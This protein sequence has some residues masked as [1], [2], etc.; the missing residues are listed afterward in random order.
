MKRLYVLWFSVLLLSFSSFAQEFRGT[1]IGR[2]TDSS[3]AVIANCEVTVRNENT[4]TVVKTTTTA[5]GTYSVPFLIPG[6]Y[7]VS[8]QTAGFRTYQRPG[9]IVQVQERVEIN[10]VLEPGGVTETVVVRAETPLL[11]TA[12]ASVG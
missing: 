1:I 9:V 2:V 10:A 8:A 12:S 5:A 7:T 11:Q 3:G 4:S 6:S